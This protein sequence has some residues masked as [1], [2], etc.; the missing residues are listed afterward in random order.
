MDI[1]ALVTLWNLTQEHPGTSGA[2]AALGV[3]LGLYNGSRFPMDLTDLRLLDG[4]NLHAAISVIAHDAGSCQREVHEWLN[5][6]SGRRDF[7]ARFE[8]MAWDYRRK[9]RVKKKEYLTE[10]SPP[11]ILL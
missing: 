4:K 10:F 5:H 9:G 1:K 8:F 11:Q 6:V 2:R 7:G 3:L